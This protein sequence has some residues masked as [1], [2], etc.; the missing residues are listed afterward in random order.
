MGVWGCEGVGVW[1]CS[2]SPAVKLYVGRGIG[3]VEC[4]KWGQ[5]GMVMHFIIT[6]PSA[7]C[8]LLCYSLLATLDRLHRDSAR[9]QCCTQI[10]YSAHTRMH[11]LRRRGH[12]QHALC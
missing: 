11:T 4:G 3:V 1:G 10:L 12:N 9:R 5:P 7:F 8:K 6:Q 2:E